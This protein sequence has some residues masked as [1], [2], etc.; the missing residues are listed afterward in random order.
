MK[1]IPRQLIAVLVV[2]EDGDPAT[3]HSAVEATTTPA[4][5]KKTPT[6][7]LSRRVGR[8]DWILHTL[9]GLR[10]FNNKL[11][12]RSQ[13]YLWATSPAQAAHL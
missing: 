4:L 2:D 13:P 8:I 6:S 7:P 3:R 1:G 10:L 5:K 12:F 11:T 9:P